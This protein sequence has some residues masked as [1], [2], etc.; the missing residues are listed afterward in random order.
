[1]E[2]IREIRGDE[3]KKFNS[4]PRSGA[5]RHV[6]FF[7]LRGAATAT[8]GFL[9]I[10]AAV[11]CAAASTDYRRHPALGRLAARLIR[12]Q[13]D[14]EFPVLG[15]HGFDF[16]ERGGLAFERCMDAG[17]GFTVQ[18][19]FRFHPID[20]LHELFRRHVAAAPFPAGEGWHPNFKLRLRPA[21]GHGAAIHRLVGNA[22]HFGEMVARVHDFTP[23]PENERQVQVGTEGGEERRG[24]HFDFVGLA[25]RKP[26]WQL[27]VYL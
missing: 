24:M 8:R 17:G 3:R 6:R 1:M 21:V 16:V 5:A 23:D 7:L 9:L 19:Q 20:D 18:R 2:E 12:A 25:F 14:P 27:E 15:I 11:V 4:S 10:S 26:V 13:F 22:F